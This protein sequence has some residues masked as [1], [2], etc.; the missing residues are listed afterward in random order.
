MAGL[1]MADNY[2]LVRSP[3]KPSL[4]V[5]VSIGPLS[6]GSIACDNY[7]HPYHSRAPSLARSLLFVVSGSEGCSASVET[8]LA[9]LLIIITGISVTI[10]Y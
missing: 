6:S 3:V 7:M 8:F 1:V 4:C 9:V 2:K 5:S 10:S